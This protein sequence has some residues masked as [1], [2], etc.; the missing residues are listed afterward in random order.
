MTFV[1]HT[2]IMKGA[3]LSSNCYTDIGRKKSLYNNFWKEEKYQIDL[4]TSERVMG[5]RVMGKKIH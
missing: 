2:S 5:S 4:N 3:K 1:Y